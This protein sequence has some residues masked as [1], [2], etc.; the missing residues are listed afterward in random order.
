MH[1]YIVSYFCFY[2][3]TLPKNLFLKFH[4]KYFEGQM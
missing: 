3:E 2:E 1:Q 4:E